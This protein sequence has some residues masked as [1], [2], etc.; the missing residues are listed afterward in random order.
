MNTHQADINTQSQSQT[1]SCHPQIFPTPEN[2]RCN[3]ADSNFHS[4]KWQISNIQKSR[5]QVISF[6]GKTVAN[7]VIVKTASKKLSVKKK[8]CLTK[9]KHKDK[10]P[11]KKVVKHSLRMSYS[12]SL[13]T[14]VSF[15]EKRNFNCLK[16]IRLIEAISIF[17]FKKVW[18]FH[19]R[20][21]N[22]TFNT[23]T[24]FPEVS[25]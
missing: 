12:K 23:R 13:L 17:F 14:M 25:F 19:F 18:I 8:Q 7:P 22:I 9:H 1:V 5:H 20:T 11:C 3:C 2:N 16:K 15:R 10:N 6:R 24:V 21:Q 4:Q